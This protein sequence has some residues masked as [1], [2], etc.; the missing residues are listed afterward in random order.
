MNLQGE[1]T[2]TLNTFD[3]LPSDAVQDLKFA[4]MHRSRGINELKAAETD[5]SKYDD[6]EQSY[7]DYQYSIDQFKLKMSG[8][9]SDATIKDLVW[10]LDS[11]SWMNACLNSLEIVEADENKALFQQKS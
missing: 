4:F 3:K 1:T 10:L 2:D 7:K 9:I 11:L 8:W 6:S 5:L